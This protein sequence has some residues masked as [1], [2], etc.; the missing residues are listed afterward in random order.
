MFV[1]ETS[2]ASPRAKSVF[3]VFGALCNCHGGLFAAARA[4]ASFSVGGRGKQIIASLF[5]GRLDL[6][7]TKPQ[8]SENNTHLSAGPAVVACASV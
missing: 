1:A 4:H 2:R 8:N 3:L 7:G 5:Q 6:E